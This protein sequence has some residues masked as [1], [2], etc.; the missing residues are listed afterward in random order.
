MEGHELCIFF[1]T[2]TL[3]PDAAYPQQLRQSVE[4]VR[5]VVSAL[6]ILPEKIILG[7]DS[8][9][10]NLVMGVLS[11]IT[12]PHP[13]IETLELNGTLAG[14]FTLSPWVSFSGGWVSEYHN[15]FKDIVNKGIGQKWSSAY[16]NG[17]PADPWNEPICAPRTWWRGLKIRQLLVIAGSEEILLSS[18]EKF[19][20]N[21]QVRLP[22]NN[23]RLYQKPRRRSFG[24]FT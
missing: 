6:S 5:Y 24:K 22:F 9:G 8:A 23:T 20:G 3:T 17:K 10:G 2:Y 14:A 21:I 7:G 16:L 13:E 15:R 4:A 11:H 12:H 19:V 18:I 1:L